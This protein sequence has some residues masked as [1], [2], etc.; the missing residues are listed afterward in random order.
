MRL[1][2]SA[3]HELRFEFTF[4]LI[5]A[6]AEKQQLLMFIVKIKHY[7]TKYAYILLN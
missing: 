6:I 1:I 4:C 3:Y 7:I 5:G 2:I